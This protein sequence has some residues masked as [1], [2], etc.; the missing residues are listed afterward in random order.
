MYLTRGWFQDQHL[1]QMLDLLRRDILLSEKADRTVELGDIW[2]ATY[3][4]AGYE[5]QD[6]YE[7]DPYF[8][9]IRGNGNR[10]SD[11][12][13]EY[14][15]FMVNVNSNHWI[16][17]VVDCKKSTVWWADSLRG[18][19]QGVRKFV[20]CITSITLIT[21]LPATDGNWGSACIILHTNILV[22]I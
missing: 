7:L 5:R 15:G 21:T 6:E 13:C 18:S 9:R 22:D 4:L 10:L 19:I 16:A 3:I 2:C 12:S 20:D 17:V 11:G 1:S 8:L 14:L